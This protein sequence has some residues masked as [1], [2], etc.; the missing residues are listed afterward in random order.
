LRIFFDQFILRSIVLVAATVCV[1]QAANSQTSDGDNQIE[2]IQVTATRR[3]VATEDIS[4]PVDVISSGEIAGGNLLTDALALKPGVFVQQTTP[5]QGAPIVRGLKGSEVLHLVDG[6]RLNNAIFRNAPTQ[7]FSLISPGTLERIEVVRGASTSLYG[8]DA[9]G[10]VVHAIS[11]IPSFERP[12]IRREALVAFDTADLS[13]TLRA[14][15]DFGDENIAAL[16][17]G[18]YHDSGNR[19]TGNGPRVGPTGYTS[20]GARAA[21]AL[22]PASDRSW[23]FD[24]QVATQPMTPRIDEL[25][26]GFGQTEPSSD[27][28]SFAPNERLFGHIRH[29]REDWV[30]GAAWNFDLGWQRIVDDRVSRGFL[31]DVRR[32]ESNQS[33]L[34]GLTISAAGVNDDGSWIVGSEIYHDTV[35]SSRVEENI[36]SGQLSTTTARFPNDSTMD[37][38]AVFANLQK[39]F[40]IRHSLTGGLRFSTIKTELAQTPSSIAASTRQNDVSA[41]FGWVVDLREQFQFTANLSYGFRAPN[42][43]DLGALGERPGNRFNIPNPDLQSERITQLDAGIRYN[44]DPLEFDL[45][46]FALHYTDRISSIFTG[47]VT[48]DGRD[49][50]QSQNVAEADI[51]GVELSGTWLLTDI[52]EA[53]F[54]LNYIRG[55][56]A[57][58]AGVAV[59]ADRVPPLNGQLRLSY[60]LSD[61]LSIEPYIN[62]ASGQDRL[63]PRDVR[64]TRIDPNGTPGWLSV[65]VQS[66]WHYSDAIRVT[67]KL[68]NLLD[69]DYRAHGSGINAVGRNFYLGFH[70][71]W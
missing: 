58:Q 67:L 24:L 23:L 45:V 54:V 25:V 3:A 69:E 34:I 14:S 20:K 53:N 26:P 64:D 18:E 2:E 6:M 36:V 17:G 56:Q 66:T 10:G 39:D 5:G 27:E 65:N 37:H 33:D 7:Y 57:E 71:I 28:F 19:Q 4:V 30:W 62:F 16:L 1:V 11:R 43:F 13:R 38:A 12:G 63:S 29:V 55:E 49:I 51:H 21:L 22:T 61:S 60:F 70:T 59:P 8:S 50:T 52:A 42:I 41:D 35:E 48:A 68:E 46:V 31:S 15:V 32:I 40:G 44:S 9:V 47:G